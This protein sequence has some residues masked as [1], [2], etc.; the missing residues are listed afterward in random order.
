CRECTGNSGD[1]GA[2][3]IGGAGQ[4]VATAAAVLVDSQRLRRYHSQV[5][6]GTAGAEEHAADDGIAAAKQ[7]GDLE[8]NVA[9]DIPHQVL[10]AG[11]GGH[12][13]AVEHTPRTG[14]EDVDAFGA[15]A[16]IVPVESVQGNLMGIA[17]GQVDIDGEAGAAVPGAGDAVVQVFGL[18]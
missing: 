9:R 5:V 4:D 6:H 11:E 1:V 3:T 14:I 10:T 12:C 15:W 8:L 18:L 16:V 7:V 17:I 13:L 2:F